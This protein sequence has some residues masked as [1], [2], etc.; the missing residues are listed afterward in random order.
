MS[1]KHV[2]SEEQPADLPDDLERDP[3]IGRS[4]GLFARTGS[5]E[6]ELIE[7]ENTVEGD[8]DNDAGAAGGVNPGVG[9][10]H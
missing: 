6:S 7:G 1:D 3:G 2:R 8:T 5:G 4:K 10:D 9:R